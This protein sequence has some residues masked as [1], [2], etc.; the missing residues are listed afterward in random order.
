M[1]RLSLL[2]GLTALLSV[3]AF[4]A[5]AQTVEPAPP[6][7][8]DPG[9]DIAAST[10]ARRARVYARVGDATVTVG[11]I[12]DAINKQSP[13]LRARYR[14]RAK[15]REL[16]DSLVRF[17]L[18]A[19]AAEREG[20]GDRAAV[21]R[22]VQQDIVQELIRVEV[23]QRITRESITDEEVRTYYESHTEE[24]SRREM[25]R[26]RHILFDSREAAEAV[27]REAREADT[28]TFRQLARQHSID[29]E[30]KL[31]GGDLRYFDREGRAAGARDE[32]PPVDAALVEAAFAL[33]EV[34]SVSSDPVQV[35]EHWSIIKL[36]G[37]R[38]AEVR[39]LE[40]VA[41]GIR[42]RL[43]R[44]RRQEAV[45]ELVRRLRQEHPPE[46]HAERARAIR[47]DPL[48]PASSLP[49]AGGHPNLPG[50]R[51]REGR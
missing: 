39:T 15:L 25:V 45:E 20:Y 2:S 36:T 9:S 26:A 17:E 40:Q 47:L 10:E 50:Q 30:T 33:T 31:R 22:A 49:R 3:V 44:E 19:A 37:R 41:D 8:D 5:A 4:V 1:L 51:S 23:D 43:W 12:E 18:M 14:D 6:P 34:G 27:L 7:E 13:F 48:P 42:L 35:G 16:A 21:V 28:R 24:F 11:D 32:D 38:P 29:T 46:I